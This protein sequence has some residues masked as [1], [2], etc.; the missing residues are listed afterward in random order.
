MMRG[1]VHSYLQESLSKMGLSEN[2]LTGKTK[3][4]SIRIQIS[5]KGLNLANYSPDTD[6]SA[7][8]VQKIKDIIKSLNLG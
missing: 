2:N 8:D 4:R 6:D 1:G 5:L 3:I 7:E